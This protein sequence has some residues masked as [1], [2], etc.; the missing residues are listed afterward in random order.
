MRDTQIHWIFKEVIPC[1]P[2][3]TFT[4]PLHWPWR[5][6]PFYFSVQPNLVTLCKLLFLTFVSTKSQTQHT[7]VAITME[8]GWFRIRHKL[9]VSFAIFIVFWA[10]YAPPSLPFLYLYWQMRQFYSWE[11]N[12]SRSRPSLGGG[13]PRC[14]LLSCLPSLFGD[15]KVRGTQL[16]CWDEPEGLDGWKAWALPSASS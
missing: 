10:Y 3:G 8:I 7:F 16:R 13:R 12:G 4:W 9:F 15:Q 14:P 6:Q 2:L 5:Y 11:P 1:F